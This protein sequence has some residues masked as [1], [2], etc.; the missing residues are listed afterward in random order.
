M[1]CNRKQNDYNQSLSKNPVLCKRLL[2]CLR[3]FKLNF[4]NDT[5]HMMEH[6]ALFQ[7]S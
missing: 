5:S 7:I 6:P 2:K 3:E 1:S 4:G